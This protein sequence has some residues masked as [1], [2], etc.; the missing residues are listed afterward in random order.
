MTLLQVVSERR[1][2][3]HELWGLRQLE[4]LVMDR[5]CSIMHYIL[6]LLA[7]RNIVVD[8]HHYDCP[9]ACCLPFKDIGD[10]RSDTPSQCRKGTA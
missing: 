5:Y 4:A 3:H 8:V 2:P 6:Q 9:E 7:Q 1:L 10:C